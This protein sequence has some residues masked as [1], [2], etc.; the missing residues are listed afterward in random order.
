MQEGGISGAFFATVDSQ[1]KVTPDPVGNITDQNSQI[2]VTKDTLFQCASLSKPVFAYLVLKLIETNKTQSAK[3]GLGKFNQFNTEFN[4]KTPLYEVFRDK[5]GK[6]LPDDENPFLK[7]CIPKDREWAKRLTAEIVLSHRTGLHIAAPEPFSFQF[8]PGT[9]YAY[10]GPGINCLQKAIEEVTGVN[11]LQILAQEN[12][13][14]KEALDMPNST[15]GSKPEAANSL[16]TTA[17]EY[18]KFIKSWINDDAL[19]YAFFTP[20][21]PFY[22]MMEDYFPQSKDRF[23]ENI[24]VR[25]DDRLCVTWGLGV[26][27]VK[28]KQGQ[29]IGAYH[30][31]DMGD[32]MAQWRAGVGA[33][34][35]PKTNRCIE[36]SVYLT[37]SPN[38]HILAELV[39]PEALKPA[40][41]YFFPTYGFAQNAKELEGT[42]YFG[43]KPS[44]LIPDIQ[45]EA[46]KT[47]KST[48]QSEQATENLAKLPKSEESFTEPNDSTQKMIQLMPLRP[49]PALELETINSQ[50]QEARTNKATQATEEIITEDEI[51]KIRI[52]PTPFSYEPS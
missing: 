38:G 5:H 52:F 36:V 47:K 44:V 49:E 45:E 30:T 41:N 18:A 17:D 12:V 40:L 25:K 29:I 48:Q 31:G 51:Q 37:K 11:D 28:D 1:S 13:F 2:K 26:G 35:D 10:S 7:K 22:S 50:E 24:V 20:V 43:L 3:T 8:E 21:E 9:F 34:I 19:N 27:L 23:V 6:T 46:N 42:N 33:T 14:R 39:L 16:K 4:L 32:E 15:F